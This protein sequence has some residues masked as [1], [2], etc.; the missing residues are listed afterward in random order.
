MTRNG[1][2]G[3]SENSPDAGL[4]STGRSFDAPML[5]RFNLGP[6]TKTQTYKHEQPATTNTEDIGNRDTP[7][8]F[9]DTQQVAPW[10]GIGQRGPLDRGV[11]QSLHRNWQPILCEV[12]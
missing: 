10:R 8:L 3:A 11:L 6:T 4:N 9:H 7:P 12:R 2:G 1:R 5:L